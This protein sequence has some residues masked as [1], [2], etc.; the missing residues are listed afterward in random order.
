MP[1]YYWQKVPFWRLNISQVNKISSTKILSKQSHTFSSFFSPFIL[2][3]TVLLPLLLLLL[4]F[5]GCRHLLASAKATFGHQPPPLIL[6][7]TIPNSYYHHVHDLIF[8]L[9]WG[10]S[11][12]SSSLL[13]GFYVGFDYGSCCLNLNKC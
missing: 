10:K 3:P 2:S 1:N 13:L 4:N 8:K 7:A 5:G 12:S 6:L 9:G 11:L